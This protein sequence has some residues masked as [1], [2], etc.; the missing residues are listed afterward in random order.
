MQSTLEQ[1][2]FELSRSDS[3]QSFNFSVNAY[4]IFDL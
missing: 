1:L 4:A 3:V 2:G